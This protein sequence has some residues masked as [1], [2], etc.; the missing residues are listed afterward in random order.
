MEKKNE[1]EKKRE[2]VNLNVILSSIIGTTR[3][4]SPEQTQDKFKIDFEE[5]QSKQ[6]DKI[7][8]YKIKRN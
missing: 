3:A 6:K 5:K 8:F 1:R 2:E 7:M 4:W